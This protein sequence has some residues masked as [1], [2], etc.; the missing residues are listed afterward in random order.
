[1]YFQSVGF[2]SKSMGF[3][4]QALYRVGAVC[5]VVEMAVAGE[6]AVRMVHDFG[7]LPPGGQWRHVFVFTNTLDHPL[8]IEA[9]DKSCSCLEIEDWPRIIAAGKSG[10]LGIRLHTVSARGPRSESVRL[11]TKGSDSSEWIF[12]ISAFVQAPIEATPEFVSL[13]ADPAAK[14]N[15]FAYV[16]ITNHLAKNV[17]LTNAISMTDRFAAKLEVIHPG[18]SYRLRI[19]AIPPFNSGNTFGTIQINTSLPEYP[20]L[21]V[22][23]LVPSKN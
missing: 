6:P 16:Q 2:A 10:A 23:A 19:E 13:K 5:V 15:A 22:T 20:R 3:F 9:A 21:E 14:T 8:E 17:I 4:K 11:R 1:M 7:R 18:R 12:E